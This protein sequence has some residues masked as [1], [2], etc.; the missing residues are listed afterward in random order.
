MLTQRFVPKPAMMILRLRSYKK[1]MVLYA[2]NS[3][4]IF[5]GDCQVVTMKIKNDTD[6]KTLESHVKN[7]IKTFKEQ[8]DFSKDKIEYYKKQHKEKIRKEK[9]LEINM[10]KIF[11]K[12]GIVPD[13][14]GLIQV[15]Q[16]GNE[17]PAKI[18]LFELAQCNRIDFADKKIPLP[19]TNFQQND[20]YPKMESVYTHNKN[21][22]RIRLTLTDIMMLQKL[23]EKYKNGFSYKYKHDGKKMSS[24]TSYPDVRI[25]LEVITGKVKRYGNIE[26][27]VN[28]D[29]MVEIAKRTGLR[30]W[31]INKN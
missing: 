7:A 1:S 31:K 17:S 21:S 2:Y 5:H 12:I 9:L 22:W 27:Y 4:E 20:S 14:D 3:F 23:F 30:V 26:M 28:T 15:W 11:E 18:H 8:C 10:L 29:T 13:K 6:E 25:Y 19:K 24:H 16:Y